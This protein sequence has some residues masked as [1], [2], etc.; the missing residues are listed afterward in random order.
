VVYLGG[1]VADSVKEFQEKTLAVMHPFTGN[2]SLN[3]CK[4]RFQQMIRVQ[5]TEI[6]H[7]LISLRA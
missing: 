5:L 3:K 2:S 4:D 7:W 1:G 6:Y